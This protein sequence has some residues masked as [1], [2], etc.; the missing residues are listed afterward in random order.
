MTV[1]LL[2]ALVGDKAVLRRLL[3]FYHYDFSEWNGDDVDDHG[4]FDHQYFD[5]YWTDPN[6]HPFLIQRTGR[7][8]GSVLVRTEG[9]SG[10]SEFFV[11]RK[12]RG[13]GVGRE[14]ARRV[15]ARFPGPWRI[16]QLHRNDAATAFWR[17]VIPAGYEETV[18]EEGTVQRFTI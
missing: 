9:V 13:A 4:E 3:Q 5:H 7:W 2:P 6:S 18:T 8:A 17:A 10:M 16:R 14:A 11:M 1:E 15:F 12:Y